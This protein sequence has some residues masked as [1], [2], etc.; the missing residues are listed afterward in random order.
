MHYPPFLVRV[1]L[2]TTRSVRARHLQ[3]MGLRE[4]SADEV[5]NGQVFIAIKPATPEFVTAVM[6]TVLHW[7]WL[8]LRP[9]L[10]GFAGGTAAFFFWN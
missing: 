1:V 10:L 6:L 4:V 3:A 8:I 7:F 5:A 2:A 9:V